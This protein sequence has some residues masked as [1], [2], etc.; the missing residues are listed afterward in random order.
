MTRKDDRGKSV[1]VSS[2][3]LRLSMAVLTVVV[4]LTVIGIRLARPTTAADAQLFRP[5]VATKNRAPRKTT[6]QKNAARV[7][8]RQSTSETQRTPTG[9]G[10]AGQNVAARRNR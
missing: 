9:N 6:A 4:L 8:S 7:N 3:R 10:A 2:F 1:G 5:R